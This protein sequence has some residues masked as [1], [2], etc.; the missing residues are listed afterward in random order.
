MSVAELSNSGPVELL[1]LLGALALALTSIGVAVAKAGGAI[2]RAYRKV[3]HFIDSVLARLSGLES[4][5]K[6]I[7]QHLGIPVDDED[8]GRA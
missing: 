7:E 2:L 3:D 8:E 1:L 6:R 5:V 4:R